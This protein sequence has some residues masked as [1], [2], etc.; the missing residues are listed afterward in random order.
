MKNDRSRTARRIA[1]VI[2]FLVSLSL[3]PPRVAADPPPPDA[4]LAAEPVDPSV[5]GS[6]ALLWKSAR[7]L[8]PLPVVDMQVDLSVTGLMVRG[9]LVQT[10][11]N[12][13][14]QVI[15]AIYVF[16]LPEAAAVDSM[17]VRLGDRL[18]RAVLREK[19]EAKAIY[20]RAKQ[21]GR[22]AG[23]VA[24]HR[25]NLFTTSVAN[26]NPGETIV[27]A[28]RYLGEVSYEDGEFGLVFPLTFTPRYTPARSDGSVPQQGIGESFVKPENPQ[29][30][31]ARIDVR[32]DSG[33][34]LENV[35]S[36]SH[37]IRWEPEG[38]AWRV[39]LEGGP[40]VADRDFVLRWRLRRDDRPEGTVFVE[41]REDGRYGL[42]MLL[43]PLPESAAGQGLPTETLFVIDVSG[44]MD[45]PSIAQAREALLQAIGRLR[46]GDTFD[47]LKFNDRNESFRERFLPARG[48]ELD[49]ARAWVASLRASGGTE[50]SP[51]LVRGMR[52]L[53]DADP[54]PAQRLVL[55]TDGAV[56]NEDEVL[57]QVTRLLGKARLH[58]IGIGSAP[59]RYLVRRLAGVG[60]GACEFIGNVAE[61]GRRMGSFLERI[62]R[63]VMSDLSLA[64]EEASS[65]ATSPIETYPQRL[66]D[67]YAGEP[68]FVSF[69]MGPSGGAA[70]ASLTGQVA[71]GPIRIDL[72]VALDTARG[73]G[74]ATRWARAKVEDLM[75]GLR[76]GADE[77]T[78]RR[79][80]I[81]V[82]QRFDL[83]TRYT[84]LVAVEE[85]PSARGA[86]TTRRVT[87]A[88]PDGSTLLEGTLPQTGTS[89][90]LLTR[91][92][93]FL[94]LAGAFVASLRRLGLR[95]RR[96]AA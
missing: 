23:L 93:L 34:A 5:A 10:F 77:P 74:V 1:C 42:M 68:L 94:L 59:N 80:V 36:A 25:P 4:P 52:M 76:R 41:D 91:L 6:G 32:I 9:N 73:S 16:P 13:T 63:P 29:A 44:S 20:E 81:G 43:P 66:P 14:S 30:P 89:G 60:R 22:K 27:V 79:E 83:V 96:N 7:G 26:I 82:A 11:H 65:A 71:G 37:P 45:G 48:S 15:E 62:D 17:E 35:R 61:A 54:W 21:E 28:L 2:L 64:W 38:A 70:R 51:A 90:P 18:I 50:I 55:I 87:G 86:A 49:E 75:D 53:A 31:R 57:A 88:L 40:V 8:V 95:W 39:R 12:P 58:I 78:V 84:S 19:E 69:R 85:F 33:V 67:L 47:I 72:G 46:P 3:L 24:Q 56:D 92:G